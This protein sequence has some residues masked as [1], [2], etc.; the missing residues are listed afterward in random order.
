MDM[1]RVAKSNHA[2]V[3]ATTAYDKISDAFV[4]GTGKDLLSIVNN[5]SDDF[6][7]DHN[8]G[9]AG[10]VVDA[11]YDLGIS[12][13]MSAYSKVSLSKIGKLIGIVIS[14]TIIVY[15]LFH[16]IFDMICRNG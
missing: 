6:K 8:N 2:S 7:S 14:N 5:F 4:H 10:Q 9:L 3:M 12:R 13:V 1:K 11:Y 16:S 15:R